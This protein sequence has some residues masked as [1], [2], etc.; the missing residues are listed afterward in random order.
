MPQ[1]EAGI[2]C[3]AA[4]CSALCGASLAALPSNGHYE[5]SKHL[6]QAWQ[7]ADHHTQD[8]L[9]HLELYMLQRTACTCLQ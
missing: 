7:W 2:H 9:K 6:Q 1:T 8:P 3:I 5:H 4:C